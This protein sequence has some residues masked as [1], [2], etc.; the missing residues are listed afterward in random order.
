MKAFKELKNDVY[1]IT[2]TKFVQ[3][4]DDVRLRLEAFI[5]GKL[6][7]VVREIQILHSN[8]STNRM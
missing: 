6:R 2:Q 1:E 4:T 5:Q 7:L 3:L 8:S